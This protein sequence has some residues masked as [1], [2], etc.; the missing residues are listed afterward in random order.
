MNTNYEAVESLVELLVKKAGFDVHKDYSEVELEKTK[1]SISSLIKER[2]RVTKD[3]KT[4]NTLLEELKVRQASWENNAEIVGK[5]LLKAYKEGKDYNSVKARIDLLTNLANKGTE[6]LTVKSVYDTTKRL[7]TEYQELLSKMSSIN[8][9]NEEEKEMDSKYKAY[10]ENKIT[11]LDKEL[12]SLDKELVSL[13]EVEL[14]EVNI[15][16]KIK[17][18]IKVLK[19]DVD[20]IDNAVSSSVTNSVK[21]DVWQRLQTAKEETNKKLETANDLLLKTTNMLEDVKKN[22]ESIK[23][24]KSSYE[25]DRGRCN[26]KLNTIKNKLEED[27][28][29]NSTLR[30]IDINNSEILRLEIEALNNKKDVIYVD[31]FKVK[32]ELIKEWS[33][34][35]D[36]P[37][38]EEIVIKEEPI[39]EEEILPEIKDIDESN[40]LEDLKLE[41]E[42]VKNSVVNKEEKNKIELDW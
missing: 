5:S 10:L 9:K 22:Q 35:N 38:K 16:S 27:N 1:N 41:I 31:A 4:I 8:Y 29:E 7:N 2:G 20:K 26:N 14:K 3:K 30:M 13:R 17:E 34:I 18:Y 36:S 21:F 33:K 39:K 23:E 42:N 6:N 24:R 15:E 40:I 28:Y 32:E 12:E 19:K 25:I 37:P 11:S